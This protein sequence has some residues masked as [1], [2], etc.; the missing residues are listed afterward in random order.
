MRFPSLRPA[1]AMAVAAALFVTAIL[2]PPVQAGLVTTEQVQSATPLQSEREQVAAFI[3]RADVRAQLSE[4][5][6]NPDEAASRVAAMTDDE[7]ARIAG[8]IGE[9]PAGGDAVGAVIGAAVLIFIVLLITDIAGLTSV[10]PFT[11]S[12]RR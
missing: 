12:A 8:R 2:P 7:V 6:V 11:K 4:M 3:A 9:T 5:G 10:F 1:Q